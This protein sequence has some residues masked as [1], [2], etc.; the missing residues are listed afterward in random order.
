LKK[1]LKPPT[2][3]RTEKRAADLDRWVKR[4]VAERR[5]ADVA[6]SLD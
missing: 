2:L 3:T 6:K 1:L 5:E 4:H